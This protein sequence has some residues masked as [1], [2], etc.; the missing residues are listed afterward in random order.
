[1]YAQIYIHY[2]LQAY[3][4]SSPLIYCYNPSHAL[5]FHAH[6]TLKVLIFI[7]GI[8]TVLV[9]LIQAVE[10]GAAPK[11]AIVKKNVKSK[12]VAK[13]WLWW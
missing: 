10:K 1:M 11:K 3:K 7:C 5:F 12:V 13:K 8:Y 2:C 9:Y 4:E 6:F